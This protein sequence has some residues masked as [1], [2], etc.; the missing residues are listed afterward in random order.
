[1]NNSIKI[2]VEVHNSIYTVE[3][4]DDYTAS[5]LV[6]HLAALMAQIGYAPTSI[7]SAMN[8]FDFGCKDKDTIYGK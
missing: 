6:E 4:S 5:E 7:Q 8:E 2:T 3:V 1:M